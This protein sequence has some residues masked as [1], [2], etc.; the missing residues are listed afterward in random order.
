MIPYRWTGEIHR[1]SDGVIVGTIRD[2]FGFSIE[3]RG[4]RQAGGYALT[5]INGPVPEQFKI[6]GVDDDA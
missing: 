6:V 4:V 5:G 2:P 1:E 3:L